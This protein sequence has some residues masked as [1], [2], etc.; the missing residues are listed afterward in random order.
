MSQSRACG[1]NLRENQRYNVPRR[2]SRFLPW[3]EKIAGATRHVA[4]AASCETRNAH[5]HAAEKARRGKP[6]R[7]L[8]PRHSLAEML[9]GRFL[10]RI[11]LRLFSPPPTRSFP[12]VSVDVKHG[13]RRSFPAGRNRGS[14]TTIVV[15][16][17][18]APCGDDLLSPSRFDDWHA[19]H[20]TE[21][22]KRQRLCKQIDAENT[23][24][25]GKGGKSTESGSRK[26]FQYRRRRTIGDAKSFLGGRVVDYEILNSPVRNYARSNSSE[27]C[28]LPTTE[29]ARRRS[30]A[31]NSL[32]HTDFLVSATPRTNRLINRW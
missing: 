28:E 14:N 31:K 4:A 10:P 1:V 24:N 22:M 32:S 25:G 27:F 16:R 12:C 9:P 2:P 18:A 26:V 23:R 17:V 15:F 13:D 6:K 7:R 20:R 29:I 5:P 19:I 8:P 3:S 21:S 11:Y 30:C